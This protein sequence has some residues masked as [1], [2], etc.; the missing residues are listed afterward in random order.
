MGFLNF[1]CIVLVFT[2]VVVIS[3]S[4]RNISLYFSELEDVEHAV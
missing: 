1:S 3:V 2:I 4:E